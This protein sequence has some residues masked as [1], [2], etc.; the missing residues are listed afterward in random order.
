[1][2]TRVQNFLSALLGALVVAVAFG[3]LA[4]GGAFD[5]ASD[6]TTTTVE[7][8]SSAS[9]SAPA[10]TKVRNATD[11]SALYQR[12]QD[13]VAY[14]A[15]SS[16]GAQTPFGQ[17]Q[18]SGSGSGFVLDKNGYIVTNQHV[19]DNATK[20]QVKLGDGDDLIDAK[21]V[22]S[23]ASSD[24]AVIKVDPADVKGGIKPLDLG[25]S[26]ALKVG[27]PTIAIGSPFGLSGTLTTG[28]VSA[29]N[30]TIESPNG[31]SIDGVIQTDAAINPGNSGGPLLNGSG[32]VIGVNAQIA[33]GGS[34]SN[35]GVGFAIPVDTVK[36]VAAQL[37]T[38]KEIKRAYLGISTGQSQDGKD[39]VVAQ[40]VAGGPSAT[41]DLKVG[42][43]I[44]S[45]DGQA[46]DTPEDVANAISDKQPG[47]SVRV[48]V[49]R[50][51]DRKTV[52][53]KLGERP[54]TANQGG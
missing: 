5:S 49:T 42:D 37:K 6:G 22:G 16:S 8:E 9:S 44:V 39:V 3:A 4:V 1:M 47:Q 23:D 10:A 25:E 33:S 35:S 32:Q 11:V 24:I 53:I 46:I 52:T 28:V 2:P 29:L 54:K 36:E 27:E 17:Q 48:V 43:K 13:S 20:V 26:K 21:V 50:G 45:V 41:S 14:I 51:S 15:V 12:V 34:A 40:I 7:Q 18:Q 31:F 19:V 38:G 30:R